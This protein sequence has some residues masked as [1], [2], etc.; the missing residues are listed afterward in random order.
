[1][2]ISRFVRK[3]DIL[4]GVI[5]CLAPATTHFLLSQSALETQKTAK[6]RARVVQS[7][8]LPK[9]DGNHLKAT[10][11]EVNYGPGEASAPH[12]HPCAVIGYVVSGAL[13]TQIK[14]EAEVTYKSG[15]SFYE[16]PNG[17]HLVSANASATEPAKL[18]AYLICDHEGPLSAN[19]SD[20][21]RQKGSA[22]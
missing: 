2:D 21:S 5:L 12:S 13:R 9:L 16:A 7:R 8:E 20:T 3:R 22:R 1:M 17:V 19:V 6:E 11:V 18:L 15:D 4:A 14:G 10:L